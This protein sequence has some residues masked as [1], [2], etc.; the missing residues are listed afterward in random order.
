MRELEGIAFSFPLSEI[1]EDTCNVVW[2][3]FKIDAGDDIGAVLFLSQPSGLRIGSGF[4]E[5]I[6]TR[7]ARV[8]LPVR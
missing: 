6:D 4:G 3:G 1:D 2:L 5:R 7:A 8:A